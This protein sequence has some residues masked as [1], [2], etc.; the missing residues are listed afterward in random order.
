MHRYKISLK[1]N[2]SHLTSRKLF[3]I[4]NRL[5]WQFLQILNYRRHKIEKR[6]GYNILTT[7]KLLF[8]INPCNSFS[9]MFIDEN[10]KNQ[11]EIVI[12]SIVFQARNKL[13]R[14][15]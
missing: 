1:I 2:K 6:M 14:Q 9:R 12:C 13:K 10:Y 4:M 11:K 3:S 5:Y 15:N 8:I 7:Y